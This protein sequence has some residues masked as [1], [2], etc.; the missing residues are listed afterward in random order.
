[1][2]TLSIA[3]FTYYK[4]DLLKQYTDH[5]A[6]VTYKQP[7]I[8]KD[9]A[10][11]FE[12]KEKWGIE[13]L[14]LRLLQHAQL[15]A[16]PRQMSN[17]SEEVIN[18]NKT[19][20]KTPINLKDIIERGWVREIWGQWFLPHNVVINLSHFKDQSHEFIP[21]LEKLKLVPY[22][23]TR[24]F[25]IDK[26][27]E[28]VEQHRITYKEFPEISWLYKE[29]IVREH[30]DTVLLNVQSKYV[31]ASA[32]FLLAKL[33]EEKVAGPDNIRDRLSWLMER[34]ELFHSGWN[35]VGSLH[36][37]AR[38]E[39]LDACLER[40]LS[41]E[42]LI[43]WDSEKLKISIER[44]LDIVE[45]PQDVSLPSQ[46]LIDQLQWC[47]K[48]HLEDYMHVNRSRMSLQVLFNWILEFETITFRSGRERFME[49]L[50]A[51]KERPAFM[52]FLLE[53][54]S[55]NQH[56]II[57]FLLTQKKYVSIGLYLLS[58]VIRDG[59]LSRNK[60]LKSDVYV[61]LW[62][63]GLWFAF[64]TLST[65]SEEE[66]VDLLI[67]IAAFLNEKVVMGSVHYNP[68]KEKVSKRN[69][70]TFLNRLGHLSET[71]IAFNV[72]GIYA[73]LNHR[74]SEMLDNEKYPFQHHLWS[75]YQWGLNES[76]TKRW[77]KE[78]MG[79]QCSLFLKQ[80]RT[81]FLSL[82]QANDYIKFHT[83][84]HPKAWI[85]IIRY[86]ER[87]DKSTWKRFIESGERLLELMED[88][89]LNHKTKLNCNLL[90]KNHINVL[91][92]LIKNWPEKKM[93]PEIV[94]TQFKGIILYGL[95]TNAKEDA[96]EFIFKLGPTFFQ[97]QKEQHL[98]LLKDTSEALMVLTRE[99]RQQVIKQFESSHGLLFAAVLYNHLTNEEEKA[100]L[101]D[102]LLPAFRQ[103]TKQQEFII[104]ELF[105]I[106]NELL[107]SEEE[108][109]VEIVV[110]LANEYEPIVKRNVEWEEWLTSV[111]LQLAYYYNNYD[112]ISMDNVPEE[113]QNKPHMKLKFSFYE[114]LVKLDKDDESI[115]EAFIHFTHLRKEEP[116]N[117]AI[118]VNQVAA[119]VRKV[120]Y[121]IKQ[122]QTDKQAKEELAVEAEG[123]F[124][125]IN[126]KFYPFE[127]LKA[128][129][130]YVSN[131]LYFYLLIEDTASFWR[132]F[133]SLTEEVQYTLKICTYAI[134]LL[135][136][137]KKWSDATIRLDRLKELYGNLPLFDQIEK[138]LKEEEGQAINVSP[139]D[140]IEQL[141]D[142][143]VVGQ[144][145]KNII[146]LQVKEQVKAI[147]GEVPWKQYLLERVIHICNKVQEYSPNLKTRDLLPGEEDRYTD[148]FKYLYDESLRMLGWTVSTQARGG[149]TS[150][151]TN[152]GRGGVGERDLTFYNGQGVNLA[153]GEALVL[154]GANTAVI[155]DHVRKAFSYDIP[156][157]NYC[158]IINWGYA[159]KVEEVWE[160]Y[161]D[162]VREKCDFGAYEILESGTLKDL[163]PDLTHVPDYQFYTKHK[164]E[165]KS[166]EAYMIHLYIDVRHIEKVSLRR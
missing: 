109:L 145:I 114:G 37:K 22:P 29:G 21:F 45:L 72:E 159:N 39:F 108:N 75:F 94:R 156:A 61:E 81:S 142:T 40:L 79:K 124:H 55:D 27:N 38:E 119:Y 115:K 65:C 95:E 47:D 84:E 70:L 91:A 118:A 160:S 128:Y 134:Q 133:H 155:T 123:L 4:D 97:K 25:I 140:F 17:L 102:K 63:E 144:A 2:E 110:E 163:F 10:N 74:L 77:N 44:T 13:F 6:T 42:D 31:E 130:I 32:C 82:P 89:N 127:D 85:N 19:E 8:E 137:E 165:H 73:L 43:G 69:W 101:R 117:V 138:E 60:Y 41:E 93:I 50:E 120:N 88:A 158:I 132:Y 28:I 139:P 98:T 121:I 52:Q 24:V 49:L 122:E 11:V 14:L 67:D 33:W 100:E 1:M 7:H 66:L 16:N 15:S 136:Y 166:E 150:N 56:T 23:D 35:F 116:D 153:L 92:N 112:F 62:E 126:E 141:Y 151:D 68:K 148:L 99:D 54:M 26:L 34:F 146:Q 87:E 106:T 80:Y 147:R 58:N 129:E 157:I 154:N 162:I 18:Y 125:D 96:T 83:I 30:E 104:P 78:T 48:N 111:R 161:K 90:L 59:E 152:T 107:N 57:P 103:A 135:I 9:D 20:P 51:A 113:Y 131:R 53:A 105:A 164:T 149:V 36:T 76:I 143:R 5:L 71:K 64:Y 86:C 46:K 12:A 3:D